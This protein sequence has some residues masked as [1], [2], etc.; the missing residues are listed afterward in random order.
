M[1]ATRDE[2]MK[3][4]PLLNDNKSARNLM[5]SFNRTIQFTLNDES[6]GFFITIE[7]DGMSLSPG[8]SARAD[9]KVSGEGAA[10]AQVVSREVDVTHMIAQGRTRVIKGK[11]SEMIL[12]TRI[13]W[14][15]K[16]A[17]Q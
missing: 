17:N 7:D 5:E 3:C 2:F 14:V 4:I 8:I 10:F 11:V 12:L 9:I 6:D 15:L 16:R 13:L 1:G